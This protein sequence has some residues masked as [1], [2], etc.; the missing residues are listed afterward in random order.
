MRVLFFVMQKRFQSGVLV[1]A[2]RFV[3]KDDRVGN[4]GKPGVLRPGG[5]GKGVGRTQRR[6]FHR[7]SAALTSWFVPAELDLLS[8]FPPAAF[9][10][11]VPCVGLLANVPVPFLSAP[12]GAAVPVVVAVLSVSAAIE[13][14][15]A[16]T[17]VA[18]VLSM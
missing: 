14:L 2:F 1:D 9:V 16:V 15:W 7:P 12:P 17:G 8:A 4:R 3:R 5:A 6:H 10:C 11:A 18:A 13:R